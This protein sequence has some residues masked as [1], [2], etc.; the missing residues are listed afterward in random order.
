MWQHYF[1]YAITSKV[2]TTIPSQCFQELLVPSLK[3]LR[4]RVDE[5]QV[6]L[7]SKEKKGYVRKNLVQKMNKYNKITR[8]QNIGKF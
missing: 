4:S 5:T 8:S 7:K 6:D 1:K 2:Y 3:K